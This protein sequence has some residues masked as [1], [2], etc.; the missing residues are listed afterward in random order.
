MAMPLK[1]LGR[2]AVLAGLPVLLTPPL[3]WHRSAQAAVRRLEVVAPWEL[4][5]L[6]PAQSGFVF[7]RMQIAEALVGTDLRGALAPALASRWAVDPD[8]TTWRFTLRSGAKFHDGTPVT[9]ASVVS[10]LE[11]ARSGGGALRD[12]PITHIRDD[13]ETVVIVTSRPFA[14]LPA[15]LADF[16]AIILAPAAYG[17]DGQVRELLGTG[18]Y[19]LSGREGTRR[20][21]AEAV[22]EA[23]LGIR[24]TAYTAVPEA[25]TRALMLQGGQADAAM[26]LSPAAWERLA[27]AGFDM[28]LAA[29]PRVRVLKV[30]AA[31][32][33]FA[34]L[35]LRRAISLGIDR[36]AIARSVLRSPDLAA[37]QLL[38]PG[39]AEWHR[40]DLAPLRYDPV[41]ARRLIEA[42]GYARRRDG[43]YA[44][45]GRT[46]GFELFTYP[47]RPEL[48]PMAEAI[49]AQLRELGLEVTLRLG[50]SSAVVQ[51]HRDGTLQAA[52]I[53]RN[54]SLLP[55]PI[56]TIAADF[57]TGGAWGAMNWQDRDLA[58]A[59]ERYEST[60]DASEAAD[61]RRSIVALLHHHLP[62]IPISWFDHR[63]G[64]S[65]R[66]SGAV[67]DPLERSYAIDRLA[68]RS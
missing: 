4:R 63:V 25:E 9:A 36:V 39:L 40:A 10:A 27:R 59:I 67:V 1:S 45:D 47:E 17:G 33:A 14:P 16:S 23:A 65:A 56:G 15:Y 64:F 24:Y 31:H 18:P 2:R 19:R 38:P 35:A 29:I 51:G 48:P 44:K 54:F 8:Q 37:T 20:I 11:R 3:S 53:A 50:D 41:E 12:A 61:V 66:I 30:N 57:R 42:A 43:L 49:Q 28:W 60:F 34:S 46:L 32:P 6:E 58:A 21:E 55:D 62:T 52:L 5:G 13:G 22:P 68:W 7:H 26:T